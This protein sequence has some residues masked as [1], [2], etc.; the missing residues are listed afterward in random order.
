LVAGYYRMAKL[1]GLHEADSRCDEME[2]AL[3]GRFAAQIEVSSQSISNTLW[4]LARRKNQNKPLL[5]ALAVHAIRRSAEFRMQDLSSI[6][7]ALA[8]LR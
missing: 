8:T 7:R 6:A 1:G 5:D 4:A 2:K 3:H